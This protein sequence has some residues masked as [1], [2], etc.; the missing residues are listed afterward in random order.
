MK[1]AVPK[2]RAPG[3][4]RVALIP[5][6]VAKFVKAGISVGVER[7]AG[8]GAQY[9]DDAYAAAGATIAPDAAA[10]YADA[11]GVARVA[12]PGDDEPDGR[13]PGT[14]LIGF[15]PPLG[16]AP[17]VERYAR[18]KLTALSM[19]TIPRT[20]KAQSMAA[21][22]SQ[23]NIAG[24]SSGLQKVSS[25]YFAL[26]YRVPNLPLF[27]HRTYT[28]VVTAQNGRGQSASSSLPITVR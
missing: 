25:G 20:T 16:D 28:I 10:L 21:L 11:A 26:S 8:V 23:A 2:E 1:I 7:G 22:S 27:L 19:D 9:P 17:S 5:E 14:I 3:E 6:T 15:L 4:N 24:Y 12:K 18:R 13:R